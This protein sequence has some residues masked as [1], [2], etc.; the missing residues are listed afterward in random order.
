MTIEQQCGD[1]V[2]ALGLAEPG[3]QIRVSPLVGGVSSDIARVDI[4]D[5]TYCV[6]FALDRL[7]V[8]E[9]WKAPTRRN[10][11][12]YAWLQFVSLIAPEAVP[13]L[14]GRSEPDGGFA[15]EFL[16]G[17][18]VYLWKDELL[19]G[20]PNSA[21]AV[22]VAST[23][24]KIHAAST[25]PDF[26]SHPFTNRDDFFALRLEPY[27][28]FTASRHRAL[29]EN[30]KAVAERLYAA[31]TVLIHGDVSPKNIFFRDGVP[32][33][34]DA[35]CATMGDA[36]F[37]VAFCVNHLILKALHRP[38]IR[39]EL[40]GSVRLFWA[41]YATRVVWEEPRDLECRVSELLPMLMLARVDGKSPVEYF[42]PARQDQVRRIAVSL[43]EKP[44][45]RISDV[46]DLVSESAE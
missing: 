42:T 15:M 39:E 23:L 22:A 36:S 31:D 29:E 34:L 33:L 12:E 3:D 11:S 41:E 9:E 35:E 27:L 13:K 18:D 28:V 43:I 46:V 7:R 16:S 10:R 40:L 30:L 25:A 37:D 2:C 5:R 44:P 17:D 8:A 45:K 19:D 14:Y 1:L 4:R 20:K 24:G 6:K 32:I 21:N 26:D 38:Q